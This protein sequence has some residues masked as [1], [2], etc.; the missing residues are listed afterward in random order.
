MT[1]KMAGGQEEGEGKERGKGE[2]GAMER[3]VRRIS[4]EKLEEAEEGD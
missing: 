3:R 4:E 1:V 2:N